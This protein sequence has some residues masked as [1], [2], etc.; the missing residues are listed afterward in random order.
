M[1]SQH[2]H[3][4]DSLAK[5]GSLTK[6]K[7]LLH[8]NKFFEVFGKATRGG[9]VL[10]KC[11]IKMFGNGQQTMKWMQIGILQLFISQAKNFSWKFRAATFHNHTMFHGTCSWQAKPE[12]KCARQSSD[13]C[14]PRDQNQRG[15]LRMEEKINLDYLTLNVYFV[16][17]GW[18]PDCGIVGVVSS[19][20]W[21]SRCFLL[22]TTIDGQKINVHFIIITFV[23]VE[24]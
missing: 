4:D 21:A 14:W 11:I 18:V 2:T 17:H 15:N 16:M 20:Q 7:E 12:T 3:T 8:W 1:H 24:Y 9:C 19:E 13:L 6:T 10:C 22:F 5:N 23:W